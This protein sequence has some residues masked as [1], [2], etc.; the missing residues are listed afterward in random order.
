MDVFYSLFQIIEKGKLIISD[1]NCEEMS[2]INASISTVFLNTRRQRC[3]FHL[4]GM[5]W[6]SH[7]LSKKFYI[8]NFYV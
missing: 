3:G 1:R 4:L 7:V 5:R 8:F 2:Q 6:N